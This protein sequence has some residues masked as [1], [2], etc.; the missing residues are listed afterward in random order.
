MIVLGQGLEFLTS[1]RARARVTGGDFLYAKV[2]VAWGLGPSSLGAPWANCHF[3][4]LLEA[5]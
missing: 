1:T 4:L 5:P 3:A 2:S